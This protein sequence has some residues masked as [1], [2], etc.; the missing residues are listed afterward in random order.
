MLFASLT[1]SLFS[2]FLAMLGKQWLNQYAS[3]DLRG[4]TIERSQ[5]RQRKL[6]GIT[7]WYFSHVMESLPL[8]LQAALLLLGCALSHYLWGIDKVVASVVLGL[9]SFGVLLYLF[10]VIAGATSVSCPYQTPGAKIICCIL[11]VIYQLADTPFFPYV[12]DNILSPLL[13]ALHTPIYSLHTFHCIP[14]IFHNVSHIPHTLHS[15]FSSWIEISFCHLFLTAVPITLHG[16]PCDL[17]ISLLFILL[18]PIWLVVDTCRAVFFLLVLPPRVVYLWLQQGSEKQT[19]VLDQ[20]CISWTLQTSLDRHVR[21][22]VLNYLTTTTPANFDPTLVVYCFNVLFDCIKVSRGDMVVITQ[23]SEQLAMIS[24]LC[25][26]HMLS[27][28]TVMDPTPRVFRSVSDQYGEAFPP[29]SYFNGLSFS[30]TIGAI[31]NVLHD[32]HFITWEGYKPSDREHT[33]VA[34]ALARIAWFEHQRSRHGKVSRW[35]IRFALHSLSSSPLPPTSVVVNCLSIIAIDL[36][37][38][39]LNSAI[40]Y[41]RCVCIQKTPPF[42]TKPSMQ[43]DEVSHLITEKLKSMVEAADPDPIRSHR[44]AISALFPYAVSLGQDGKQGMIDLFS[45][46]A[47][48]LTSGEFIWYHIGP[49]ITTL[50]N[51]PIPS[52]LNLVVTLASPH[53]PWDDTQDDGDVIARWAEAASAIPYT[54]A[55]GQAVVDALLHIASIDFLQS[56]IP[57]DMWAWLEKQPLHFPRYLEGSMTA[58][59]K[60]VHQVQAF[61]SIGILRSYLLLV[62]SRWK[63][64]LYPDNSLTEIQTLLKANFSGIGMKHYQEDLIEGLNHII[65]QTNQFVEGLNRQYH[66]DYIQAIKRQH[67]ELKTILLEIDREA[68]DILIRKSSRLI[69][70]NLLTPVGM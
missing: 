65:R 35:L 14:L 33:I 17:A 63:L 70:F 59:M 69:P 52:S 48:T 11:G 43:L 68:V 36:S 5:N 41:E 62:W 29:W 53:L 38:R 28:L 1:A 37:H 18:L 46:V 42:L 64:S 56:Q 66:G 44:K 54:E 26:L 58:Q 60:V 45:Q 3:V 2:A 67:E 21:L 9:T 16:N 22:S 10:I 61:G 30:H 24:A 55:V 23:E 34:H 8:M 15:F 7:N 19:A 57:I 12:P 47:G 20:H 13:N 40:S 51:K 25:C 39:P 32:E 4:S 50:F 6:D 27:H 49:Y 31:H